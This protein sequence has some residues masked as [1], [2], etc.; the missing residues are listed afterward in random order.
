MLTI[1]QTKKGWRDARWSKTGLLPIGRTEAALEFL[2]EASNFPAFY[3]LFG[4]WGAGKT[5][6][7][8]GFNKVNRDAIYIEARPRERENRFFRRLGEMLNVTGNLPFVTVIHEIALRLRGTSTMSSDEEP[9]QHENAPFPQKRRTLLV[10]ESHL[11]SSPAYDCLRWLADAHPSD[12]IFGKVSVVLAGS[13][14][15]DNKMN[16]PRYGDII[17]RRLGEF[18]LP[19]PTESDVRALL[20][21]LGFN[22]N[23]QHYITSQTVARG[24]TLHMV[25]SY[26]QGAF[27]YAKRKNIKTFEI[28][29]QH[30]MRSMEA[31]QA[32]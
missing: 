22:E 27:H 3:F 26:L 32:V 30:F 19:V 15:L 8:E 29:P 21:S 17:A 24:G 16:H 13:M 11:L 2:E 20:D 10:D 5:A 1:H 25:E 6:I 28:Q 14:R 7:L 18:H 9:H 4:T 23:M 12:G 31:A